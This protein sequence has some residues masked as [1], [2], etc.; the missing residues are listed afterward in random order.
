MT[1]VKSLLSDF[2]QNFRP[3][4]A[5]DEIS[6]LA[7]VDSDLIPNANALETSHEDYL[8]GGHPPEKRLRS[9]SDDEFSD[10]LPKRQKIDQA[11]STSSQDGL[12]NDF[13]DLVD[14][15]M[16]VNMALMCMT[17]LLLEY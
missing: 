4:P 3:E 12:T 5:G 9:S 17:N 13:F 6:I 7:S 10:L 14:Q 1:E 15:E 11:A 2:R 8:P 16:P